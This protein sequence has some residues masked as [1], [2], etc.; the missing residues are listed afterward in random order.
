L[1]FFVQR[2]SGFCRWVAAENVAEAMAQLMEVAKIARVATDGKP[3]RQWVSEMYQALDE[4]A[5]RDQVA[6]DKLNHF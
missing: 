6:K 3:T 5:F 2:Y 1:F 4:G